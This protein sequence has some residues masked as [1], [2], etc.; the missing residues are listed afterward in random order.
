MTDTRSTTIAQASRE[1]EN[2]RL[3]VAY[4]AKAISAKLQTSL[5]SLD[6]REA[7]VQELAKVEWKDGGYVQQV[8][9]ETNR[10]ID[11][12]RFVSLQKSR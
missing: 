9:R 2:I 7:L 1:Y 5:S 6:L 11:A 4:S 10:P 8:E 3:T 12:E